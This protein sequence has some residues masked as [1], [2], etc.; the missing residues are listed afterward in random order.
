MNPDLMSLGDDAALLVLVQ[1]SR[2]GRHIEAGF[3]AVTLEDIENPRDTHTI[4]VLA[5]AQAAD[6]C[7]ALAQFACFVVAVERECHCAA[8][9]AGPRFGPE[10]APGA[11]PIHQCA[12]GFFRPLPRLCNPIYRRWVAHCSILLRV[13]ELVTTVVT[14]GSRGN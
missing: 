9:S 7:A 13:L 12:P 1:Q 3:D 10:S 4:A 2:D 14:D 5:P 11:R 6:R 8:G